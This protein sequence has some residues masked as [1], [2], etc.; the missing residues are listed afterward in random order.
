MALPSIVSGS[1]KLYRA[2]KRSK[3]SW[4]DGGRPTSA[5]YKDDGGNSANRDGNRELGQIIDFMK[6][7]NLSGRVKGIVRIAAEDCYGV[8][9]A[10]TADPSVNNPYHVN[11]WLNTD[12]EN[13]Q[14]LRALQ[15][16]DKS[17]IVYFDDSI[18]W[19]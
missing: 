13:L 18:K 8:G 14:N 4:L 17:Q 9:T 1:E 16:A 2:I 11:I 19:T 7:G 10:I 3:P 6:N 12:K 15:L 5:M